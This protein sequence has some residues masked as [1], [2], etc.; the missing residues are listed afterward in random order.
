VPLAAPLAVRDVWALFEERHQGE[1]L[2]RL[3]RDAV[4]LPAVERRHDVCVGG[5]QVQSAGERT[6]V[7]SHHLAGFMLDESTKAPVTYGNLSPTGGR[8]LVDARVFA[9]L[10]GA[11][12]PFVAVLD[13]GAKPRSDGGSITVDLRTDNRWDES[14]RWVYALP[15]EKSL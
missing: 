5:V 14:G 8:W 11:G 13:E 9:L 4:V 3:Q 15:G 12:A 1:R 7:S 10:N 6:H 2:V